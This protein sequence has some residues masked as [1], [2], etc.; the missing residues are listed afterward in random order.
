MAYEEY[1]PTQDETEDQIRSHVYQAEAEIRRLKALL[2][3]AREREE[4]AE[5]EAD[6]LR[7]EFQDLERKATTEYK[8]A[9]VFRENSPRLLKENKELKARVDRAEWVRDQ[10]KLEATLWKDEARAQRFEAAARG[11]RIHELEEAAVE[12][13]DRLASI[14]ALE[15]VAKKA[16]ELT[17]VAC[18]S[19]CAYMVPPGA[20][21]ALTE[22]QI[23]AKA[24]G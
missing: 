4:E 19:G 6:R 18:R 16:E 5:R 13:A 8:M 2:F 12:S 9:Q 22:A 21:L 17:S 23:E 10:I 3:D 7:A 20:M 15:T 1:R 14:V 11:K 24:Q